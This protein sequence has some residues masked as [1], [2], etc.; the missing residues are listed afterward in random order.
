MPRKI[1][2]L[3]R[4]LEKAGFVGRGGK[5]SHRNY[6]HPKG[7][8]VTVSGKL[9]DDAKPYQEKEVGRRIEESRG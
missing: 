3:I 9:G 6:E 5:G 2:A 8:R 7:I 1:R 4:E